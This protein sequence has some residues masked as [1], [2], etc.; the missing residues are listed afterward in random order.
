MTL[1]VA[2]RGASQA[3]PENTF[4]A[5]R[6]AVDAGADAIELDVHLTADG[7][8]A[9]MHDPTLDRTTDRTIT[10]AAAT[11]AE[12]READAGWGFLGEDGD[13]PFRGTGLTVPTLPEV[14]A[15]LPAGVG[16]AVEIKAAAAADGVVAALSGSTVRAAAA[17]TVMSFQEGAID[18]VRELAPDIP[19]GLLLVPGDEFERGLKWVVE[20]GHVAVMPFD[21]DVG[22]DP[23]ENVRLATAWGARVGCYVVNDPE[24]MQQL[25]AAG[26]WGFVTDVPDVARTVLGPR[27]RA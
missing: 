14:V 5:F 21:P 26:A 8:L 7:E 19:T 27:Q 18:R 4:E 25:A 11:M 6:R 15:W 16:L 12:I 3:A 2:H 22:V 24:R 23:A 13:Y 1:V 10:V 20:H 17:V 9:V